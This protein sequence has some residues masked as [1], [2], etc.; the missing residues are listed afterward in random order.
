[1]LEEM[2]TLD[3][4]ERDVADIRGLEYCSGLEYLDLG[5]NKISD[6]RPLLKNEG[7]DAGDVNHLEGNPPSPVTVSI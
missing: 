7:V 3:A 6:I 5:C 2:Q 1:M 4:S